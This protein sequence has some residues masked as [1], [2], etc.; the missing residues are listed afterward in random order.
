MTALEIALGG[1]GSDR[2]SMGDVSIYKRPESVLVIVYTVAREVLML[3][4][5]RPA[6]YWQS[7]TGGLEWGEPPLQAAYRELYEETGLRGRSI[8]DCRRSHF[9]TIYPMFRYRYAPGVSLNLEHVF[10]CRLD[11]PEFV[12]VDPREHD[13]CRW[14]GLE[15]ALNLAVSHTNREA[16]ERCVAQDAEFGYA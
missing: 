9:F 5:S 1:A 14:V 15:E 10:R 4:R 11:R 6:G 2:K 13:D 12:R 7:V 8:E 16:L 3:R